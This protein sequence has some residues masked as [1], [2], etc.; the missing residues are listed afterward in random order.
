MLHYRLPNM[1]MREGFANVAGTKK[2]HGL[3]FVVVKHATLIADS[4]INQ[5]NIHL[6][7]LNFQIIYRGRRLFNI[8]KIELL[9]FS[10]S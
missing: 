1:T 5:V 3:I 9:H 8:S 10:T 2:T 6:I 7:R 4:E